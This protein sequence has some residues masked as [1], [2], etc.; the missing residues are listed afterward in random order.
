[1]PPPQ[2]SELE[3]SPLRGQGEEGLAVLVAA[4]WVQALCSA[5]MLLVPT[6]APQIA[7]AF[8]LPT[9][10]VGLQVSLLYGIAMLASLQAAVL[11]RRVGACRASQLAL[12]L[13]VVGCMVALAGTPMALFVT[14]MLLGVAYG[15]TNPAA[16]QLLARFTPP[17]RRNLVYS[18]KQ[19]GVPLGGILA[20]LAAPPLASLWNWQ[21]VFL[22]LG[23]AT[24][25]TALLLQIRRQRW[26]S[27]RD[28]AVRMQGVGSLTVLHRHRPLFWM[29]LAGFCLAAAQLSLLSFAVAFMVEELFIT[30]VAAG[31]IISFMHAA[32]VLGRIGWGMLADRL[33]RSLPVLFGLSVAMAGLFV[34]ISAL[35]GVLPQWLAVLLLV[36]A[37]ATAIGWNGVYLA[38]VARRSH[39]AEVGEATAAVLVLTYMGV[40]VGPALFS[41]IVGLSD[42]YALGFLLPAVAAMLAIVCLANCRRAGDAGASRT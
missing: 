14:T 6:L 21:A 30:L 15:M 42:S 1:M 13:V 24:L 34:L 10:L 28:A 5:G 41:L 25:L 29:G 31:V 16:A 8:G 36:M 26:D 9:G 23:G 19:T 20:G 12:S 35:G 4:T 37:G 33:G 18:I 32:G 22:I 27:D 38:E 17:E 40:L 11:A 3:T 39:P 7:A 2:P